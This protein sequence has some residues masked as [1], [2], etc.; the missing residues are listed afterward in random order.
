MNIKHNHLASYKEKYEKL[1]KITKKQE[2]LF[3]LL[4]DSYKE[5]KDYS[6]IV[7][8]WK[9]YDGDLNQYKGKPY[10]EFHNETILLGQNREPHLG[11]RFILVED[12]IK[13][14]PNYELIKNNFKNL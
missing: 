8:Y 11:A 7:K 2:L 6:S 1:I 14:V 12:L 4:F 10:I 3:D 5:L 13:A 9:I